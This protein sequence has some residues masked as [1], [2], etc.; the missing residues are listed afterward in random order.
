VYVK[1]GFQLS[2]SN[3]KSMEAVERVQGSK[4]K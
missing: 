2:D 3:R 1:T 4:G